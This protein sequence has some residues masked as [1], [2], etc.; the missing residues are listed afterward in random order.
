MKKFCFDIHYTAA[1]FALMRKS[2]I[3]WALLADSESL[4]GVL[5]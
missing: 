2:H 5:L 4:V 3:E 1:L